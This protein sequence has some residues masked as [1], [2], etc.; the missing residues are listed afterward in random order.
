MAGIKLRLNNVQTSKGAST[1]LAILHENGWISF[2]AQNGWQFAYAFKLNSPASKIIFESSFRHLAALTETGQV[3]VW[4]MKG[5]DAKF[6]WGL[7]FHSVA[8][9]EANTTVEN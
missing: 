6:E 7:Q 1:T 4:R 2:W 8:C 9:I 3:E 5:V